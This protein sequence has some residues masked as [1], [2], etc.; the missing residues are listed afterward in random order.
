MEILVPVDFYWI[1]IVEHNSETLS[2]PPNTPNINKQFW[3]PPD[4]VKVLPQNKPNV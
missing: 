1:Q 2:A 4:R 3:F